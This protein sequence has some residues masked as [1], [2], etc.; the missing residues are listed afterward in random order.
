VIDLASFLCWFDAFAGDADPYTAVAEPGA[1]FFAV[2]GLVRVQL[3][4][5]LTAAGPGSLSPEA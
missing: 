4:A 5:T 2:L 3:A 1:E